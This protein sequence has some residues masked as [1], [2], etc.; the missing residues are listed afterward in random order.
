MVKGFDA[1]RPEETRPRSPGESTQRSME[2][3]HRGMLVE[4]QARHLLCVRSRQYC[5]SKGGWGMKCLRLFLALLVAGVLVSCGAIDES[6]SSTSGPGGPPSTRTDAGEPPPPPT[7]AALEPGVSVADGD[8]STAASE[9][10]GELQ[11]EEQF[12][13][14][15][16]VDRT[17]IVLRWFGAHTPQ[18]KD[19]IGRFPDL[20][21]TIEQV[22]CSPGQVRAFGAELFE[23]NPDARSFAL[24]PDGL[25]AMVVL[26]E[27]LRATADVSDLE[28]RYSEAAGCP[29]EVSFG[30]VEP[31]L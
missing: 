22:S 20:D 1:T 6:S 15:E 19:V 18:M 31:A 30:S 28:R 12:A 26:D 14:L 13:S 4:V 16:V 25:S 3:P 29:V 7:D 8:V 5:G 23:T 2:D 11:G 17:R 24:E 10:T 27:S 21:I 9:I